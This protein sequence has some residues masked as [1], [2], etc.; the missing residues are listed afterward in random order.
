MP[1]P[2]ARIQQGGRSLGREEIKHNRGRRVFTAA[3][4]VDR[5]I[6]T[7]DFFCSSHPG[8]S[9]RGTHVG[10]L[11]RRDCSLLDRLP[12]ER[13]LY[14][15]RLYTIRERG[16]HDPISH[17][18]GEGHRAAPVQCLGAARGPKRAPA[19]NDRE[20]EKRYS[21]FLS[22][23]GSFKFWRPKSVPEVRFGNKKFCLEVFSELFLSD[24]GGSS[25][26]FH[27]LRGI[28]R[29]RPGPA[30]PAWEWAF[31]FW[32]LY[33]SSALLTLSG[34]LDPSRSVADAAGSR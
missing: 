14:F 18:Y 27:S 22:C 32:W 6:D 33:Q 3:E 16:E 12:V 13:A 8:I 17:L 26:F 2:V 28:R 11:R 15:S 5:S 9:F 4:V 31:L 29:S 7:I 1:P 34:P 24:P 20:K 10:R 21:H 30:P 19:P 25:C 23:L